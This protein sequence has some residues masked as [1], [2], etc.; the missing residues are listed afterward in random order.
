M[1]AYLIVE[2]EIHDQETYAEF[3]RQIP[4]VVK[5]YRGRVR[6]GPVV[7]LSSLGGGRSSSSIR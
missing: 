6:G 3:I 4:P 5:Q 2:I 7:P 1:V